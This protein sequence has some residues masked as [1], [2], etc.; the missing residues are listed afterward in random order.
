M[1]EVQISEADLGLRK[2]PEA[3]F[4]EV[5]RLVY[6]EGACQKLDSIRV[7]QLP[8]RESQRISRYDEEPS[9]KSLPYLPQAEQHTLGLRPVL[10]GLLENQ[11]LLHELANL[12]EGSTIDRE[13]LKKHLGT[14]SFP[15]TEQLDFLLN[16]NIDPELIP[17][18][19]ANMGSKAGEI[20]DTLI[21]SLAK[22]E[23]LR[24]RLATTLINLRSRALGKAN[25]LDSITNEVNGFINE[26]VG[27]LA[28]NPQATQ[29]QVSSLRE[30]LQGFFDLEGKQRITPALEFTSKLQDISL[31]TYF[32][33]RYRRPPAISV[34]DEGETE[35]WFP[36]SAYN[37]KSV[38]E[39]IRQHA[40][41][42][43]NGRY[44]LLLYHRIKD[45]YRHFFPEIYEE[46]DIDHLK[47]VDPRPSERWESNLAPVERFEDVNGAY[48]PQDKS[49]DIK[50]GTLVTVGGEEAFAEETYTFGTDKRIRRR[51][52]DTVVMAHELTHAVYD[53]IVGRHSNITRED[54]YQQTADHAINE[55]FAVMM[56]LL[57]IDALKAN[58]SLLNL[59]QR[60]LEDLEIRKKARLFDLKKNKTGYT[61]GTYRILHRVYTE[62]AGRGN[63]RD[64]Q[65]GLTAIRQ[66]IHSLN[67]DRTR[68]VLRTDPQY[69]ALLG[70]GTPAQWKEYFSQAPR[71]ALADAA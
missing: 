6:S 68:Q 5:R 12:P 41:A 42:T 33:V 27:S 40:K 61:E 28:K 49:I 51:V 22:D 70:N 69:I 20:P 64:M 57:L 10:S 66:F 53:K 52:T 21:Q 45:L 4:Q 37:N 56:E 34:L 26:T 29:E 2:G 63:Q 7:R 9:E 39:D 46:P 47:L 13:T 30:Y 60:D 38:L 32:E 11:G 48:H 65:T 24:R 16:H 58:P 67:P 14:S 55:G 18:A 71:E 59:D 36:P 43:E 8:F 15:L 3:T 50:S 54:N 44:L 23:F 31:K 62:G 19:L 25:S 17:F 35:S 1:A